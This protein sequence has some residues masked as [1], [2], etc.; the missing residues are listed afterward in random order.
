M[1][2]YNRAGAGGTLHAPKFNGT[3][4]PDPI[5]LIRSFDSETIPTRP[6]RPSPLSAS[7]F[8]DLPLDLLD[9]L[10]SFPL[11]QAAP[12]SFLAAIGT[13]LRY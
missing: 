1:R 10:R 9:R 3:A 11:F 13:F 8:Q 12:D 5:S 4:I 6:V 2:R 7:T